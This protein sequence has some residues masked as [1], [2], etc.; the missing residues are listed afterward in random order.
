[1]IDLL[2]IILGLAGLWFGT[3][4]VIK[5]AL[6]IA[7]FLNLSEVFVGIAI[8]AIGTDLP[9]IVV[10]LD[11]AI[12]S[13]A[14]DVDTSGIIA[15]NAIGSAFSQISMVLG[16]S[17]LMGYLTMS[18]KQLFGDGALL[19]GSVLMFF[20]LSLDGK[21]GRIDGIILI[22][23]YA[24]YYF[25]LF[26]RETLK[27]KVHKKKSANIYKDILMLLVGMAIVIFTSDLVVDHSILLT[28]RLG[29]RQSFVG[30]I[31]I[32]MGTSLPELALSINAMR[33][34]AHGLSVGNLVG[35]NIFDML[36][37]VGLGSTIAP[38]HVE[39]S[40]LWFDVPFLFVLSFL[41][42]F[43]FRKKKGLQKMEAMSLIF[44]F[45]LYAALK[46]AGV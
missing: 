46:L 16:M 34:K 43:F 3:E 28:N 36:I 17:G 4:L 33:K 19:L 32:G 8:L 20:L 13:A 35:S 31:M 45:V 38:I 11:A 44:A 40:L 23:T 41:V 24:V 39:K 7:D 5:G 22:T 37:P 14:F 29:I 42:L 1:M 2:L 15:G 18:R 21:L 6:N 9:E 27:E 26:Q 10:A 30:I 25:T 12:E